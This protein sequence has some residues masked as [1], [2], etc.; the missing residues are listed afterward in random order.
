[1][2]GKSMKK[3]LRF[4]LKSAICM[5]WFR[6]HGIQSQSV[7]CDGRLPVLYRTGTVK[8][9]ERLTIRGRIARC[10]IGAARGAEV[11]IGN[12]VFINQG[13]VITAT[14]S[15]KIGENTF[16]DDF[17]SI[18]DSNY[19][20]VDPLHENSP[21][22]VIVEANVWLGRGVTVLPGSHIGKNA[23]V[24]PQSVVRGS[25]PPC[26]LAAGNP[27]K[28]VRQLNIPAGWQRS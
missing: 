10:E 18:Y 20:P 21:E 23:V 13:V 19:H 4:Y 24:A 9:G 28:V 15:I 16:I 3:S 17:V 26:V 12:G 14:K 7:E 25:L 1:M 5:A 22:P 27:A 2:A 8:I 11:A 6:I